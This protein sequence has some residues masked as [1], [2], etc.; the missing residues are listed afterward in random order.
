VKI[1]TTQPSNHYPVPLLE[2][3]DADWPL[4]DGI[5]RKPLVAT[6]RI[7]RLKLNTDEHPGATAPD[8]ST[9]YMSGV[10]AFRSEVRD[11]VFPIGADG[12]EFLP[13]LVAGAPW[14]LANCLTTLKSYDVRTSR[15][16]RGLT[17]EIYLVDRLNL[18]AGPTSGEVFTIEDSNRAELFVLESFKQRIERSKLNGITFREIG[19]VR[20]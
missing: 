11:V 14:L 18:L 20:A 2:D 10:V 8:I 16:F 12:I 19:R 4:F 7:P 1:F 3:F 17:G 5:N 15:F 13:I 6:W 9:L